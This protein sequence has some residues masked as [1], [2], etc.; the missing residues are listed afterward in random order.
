MDTRYSLPTPLLH[1]HPPTPPQPSRMSPL[2]SPPLLPLICIFQLP[3]EKPGNGFDSNC[4]T[5][6]TEFMHKVARTLT[7]Y[8]VERLASDPGFRD[9]K[10]LPLLILFI[11]LY[12]TLLVYLYITV[13]MLCIHFLHDTYY[14]HNYILVPSSILIIFYS[15][16][17]L[18][19]SSL[20][21]SPLSCPPRSSY[22]TPPSQERVST[23]SWSSSANNARNQ[24]TTLTR[25][26]A[27]AGSTQTS[28]CSASQRTS[29][30]SPCC[31]R[32]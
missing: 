12:I 27:S 25:G 23:R 18:T 16:Y 21:S 9:V 13:I 15:S 7:K 10:V 31:V 2:L 32:W 19:S 1:L 11:L 17:L 30:T 8:A 28:S 4:I 6:G 20:L 26:I 3:E 5:P 29:R 22:Q 24:D 14:D